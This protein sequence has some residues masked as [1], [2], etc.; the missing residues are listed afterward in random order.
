MGHS[1]ADKAASHDA[2]LEVAA[3]RFRELGI[4]GIGVA[5]VMREAGLTVG[6]F[7]KHFESREELVAEALAAAFK[8]LDVW[9]DNA[10]DLAASIRGY[11]STQHRDDP[12]SGCAMGALLGD[13]GR[14]SEAIRDIYTKRITRNLEFFHERMADQPPAERRAKALAIL[15][16]M[17]GAIGLSRA[18]NNPVLSNEILST[19][20][21]HLIAQLPKDTNRG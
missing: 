21:R 15:C 13:V 20:A 18:V 10:D 12:G 8:D 3:K 16:S 6:G 14:G 9:E 7:Y 19:V 4:D 1:Q 11:L 17:L 5:D 2:I